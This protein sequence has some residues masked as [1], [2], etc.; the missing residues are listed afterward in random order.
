[1][2]MGG[3]KPP[4]DRKDAS[5]CGKLPGG[6]EPLSGWQ[7]SCSFPGVPH[8]HP[9]FSD[10]R[11]LV[12]IAAR[13]PK[14]RKPLLRSPLVALH[15]A[16]D[17]SER[18][19]GGILALGG[20][21]ITLSLCGALWATN[22][23]RAENGTFQPT[24]GS[25]EALAPRV[26]VTAPPISSAATFNPS[27]NR[28]TGPR[29]R[30]ATSA[31]LRRE[32]LTLMLRTGFSDDEVIAA[33]AGKQSTVAMGPNEAR[34]LRAMGAGNRLIGYLYKQV[35]Y[36]AP[37]SAAPDVSTAPLAPV[38]APA[39][40]RAPAAAPYPV[41]D[42]AARDRQI[43][44]LKRQIDALDEQMRIVRSTPR[45]RRYWW[46]YAGSNGMV[47]QQRYDAYCQQIDNERN[48]LRRQKWQL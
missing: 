27:V 15:T 2:E 3:G 43:T 45:D 29:A 10:Y 13:P 1:M 5:G 14:G 24:P 34:Q 33:A 36:N 47:D 25:N 17:L 42:Y 23:Y 21:L 41:I 16:P 9:P 48:D 4:T 46:H 39:A 8:D 30:P 35:V 31:P 20:A 40:N 6:R 44:D 11:S 22:H 26:V 32:D 38:N 12:T 7:Q 19:S 37:L 28:R 18:V